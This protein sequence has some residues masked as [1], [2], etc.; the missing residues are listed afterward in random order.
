MSP[1]TAE[2]SP[3]AAQQTF[4]LSLI[5]DKASARM[6]QALSLYFMVGTAWRI[7]KRWHDKVRTET[8]FTIAITGSDDLYPDVH[9]WLLAKLPPNRRRSLVAR[10]GRGSNGKDVPAGP[11]G[12]PKPTFQ[13]YYDGDRR[14]K[15]N[16]DGHEIEVQVERVEAP[17]RGGMDGDEGAWLAH[18]R[19]I[20]FSAKDVEGR[21]AILRFLAEVA[22]KR[23][24][25]D[26]RLFVA[27]GW[28]GWSRQSDVP[29][30]TLESVVLR[31]GQRENL[32]EDL[33]DF[34]RKESAYG[35][36]GIPWHRGLLF[37]GPPGTGKT[38][39]AKALA[40]HLRLDVYYLPLPAIPS[41]AALLELLTGVEPRSLLLIE[42]IDVV[43]NTHD[44]ARTDNNPGVT[45][46]G[47]LNAL[48]GFV[49]P[50]GLV[51]VM[52]TNDRDVLDRA[53]VRPGRVDRH[54]SFPLLDDDQ[55][56]RLASTFVGR[57]VDLPALSGDLSPA[58]AL[59]AIKSN[60]GDPEGAI[61][62]LKEMVG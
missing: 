27:R 18:T 56:S 22:A 6:K 41:D 57:P 60:I 49:T 45:L 20:V 55:L 3:D 34:L 16:L 24:L 26:P 35:E 59:E 47:L 30:R 61:A 10:S 43:H 39:A 32:V 42:D 40:S 37:W 21:E 14:Q 51:T 31:S 44:R 28:G 36:L 38:S 23:E 52:T 13:L 12:P 11:G 54:E 2:S 5:G 33:T 46:G 48:D 15:V 1:P 62:A 17:R 29:I 25:R 19:R 4:L 9:D 8:T 53:L 50:H 58:Q 7:G